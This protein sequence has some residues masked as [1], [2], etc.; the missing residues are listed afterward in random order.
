MSFWDR[1]ST[2]PGST[3]PHGTAIDFC[4]SVTLM[5]P[6]IRGVDDVDEIDAM[7]WDRPAVRGATNQSSSSSSLS[8]PYAFS[9]AFSVSFSNRAPDR[10]CYGPAQRVLPCS[11]S[12]RSW[13]VAV[14]LVVRDFLSAS[15]RSR[16]L[17]RAVRSWSRIAGRVSS[18]YAAAA[19]AGSAGVERERDLL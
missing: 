15:S 2:S 19:W 10:I 9:P 7:H 11:R 14:C 12:R 16:R 17:A 3:S 8:S 4:P 1:T 5:N 18:K 13:L 6:R